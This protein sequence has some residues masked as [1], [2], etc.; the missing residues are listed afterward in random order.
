MAKWF[1]TLLWVAFLA[2]M[3]LVAL[4]D[5][6]NDTIRRVMCIALAPLAAYLALYAFLIDADGFIPLDWIT[7][8]SPPPMLYVIAWPLAAGAGVLFFFFDKLPADVQRGLAAFLGFLS[9]SA[10]MKAVHWR[11]QSQRDGPPRTRAVATEELIFA[12]TWI[13]FVWAVTWAVVTGEL[14]RLAQA[15]AIVLLGTLTL[16]SACCGLSL[17]IRNQVFAVE[18]SW[19][20]LGGG[21]G[22]W[23]LSL[24]AALLLAAAFFGGATVMVTQPAVKLSGD[25]AIQTA[26]KSPDRKAGPSAVKPSDTSVSPPAG[27]SSSGSAA[28]PPAGT[29]PKSSAP[30]APEGR[31]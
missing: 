9:I 31:E 6:V 21:V 10:T 12:G 22:G 30:A 11:R 20:G 25:K 17:L 23:R 18:G 13:V 19:G 26:D 7:R 28:N 29:T 4:L 16:C 24:P 1:I 5:V 27:K 15:G 3:V 2:V 8:K 14:T